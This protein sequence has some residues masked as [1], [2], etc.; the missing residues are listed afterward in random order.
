MKGIGIKLMATEELTYACGKGFLLSRDKNGNLIPF[1]V[2]VRDQDIISMNNNSISGAVINE[3][4]ENNPL[5]TTSTYRAGQHTIFKYRGFEVEADSNTNIIIARKSFNVSRDL[6]FKTEGNLTEL[7]S[8]EF[9]LPIPVKVNG[10]FSVNLTI[11]GS[12]DSVKSA[13]ASVDLTRRLSENSTYYVGGKV[14]LV[15]MYYG[16]DHNYNEIED[17]INSNLYLTI[18]GEI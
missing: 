9:T 15:N 14:S 2:K 3:I 10:D 6:T 7:I 17:Y 5:I 12:N 13:T 8:D 4:L 16:F 1:F 18:T 11:A